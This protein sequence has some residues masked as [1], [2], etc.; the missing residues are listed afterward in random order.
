MGDSNMPIAE[1]WMHSRMDRMRRSCSGY[2]RS[3]GKSNPT[4]SAVDDDD[5]DDDD[6]DESPSWEDWM[7]RRCESLIFISNLSFSVPKLNTRPVA[8]Q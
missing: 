7:D 3:K 6:D 1:D 4:P 2:G 8:N 5:D